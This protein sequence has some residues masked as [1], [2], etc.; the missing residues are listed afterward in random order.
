MNYVELG[1]MNDELRSEYG[2]ANSLH[3]LPHLNLSLQDIVHKNFNFSND[4]YIQVLTF[5]RFIF[6]NFW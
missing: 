5:S 3:E 4:Q 6:L 2:L 1:S